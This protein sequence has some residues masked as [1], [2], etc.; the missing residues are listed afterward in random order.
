MRIGRLGVVPRVV[1]QVRILVL[2][3]VLCVA[4][5]RESVLVVEGA[6]SLGLPAVIQA[7]GGTSNLTSPSGVFEF[8]FYPAPGAAG[9]YGVAIWYAQLPSSVRTV[10]WI[11]AGRD[12]TL[13]SL[14]YLQLNSQGAVLQL[15]DPAGSAQQPVWQYANYTGVSNLTNPS[16]IIPAPGGSE[17]VSSLFVLRINQVCPRC[18][19]LIFLNSGFTV[20]V[21]M[22]LEQCHEP[23]VARHGE[24]GAR[25]RD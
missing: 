15:F 8:G 21:C 7:S 12:T 9:R 13:S 6:S 2:L 18:F 5:Q 1:A 22:S 23:G 4:A 24:F 3:V 17:F 10:V 14:A 19:S 16:C 11:L 25:G 20:S